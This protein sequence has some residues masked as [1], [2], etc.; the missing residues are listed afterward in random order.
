[1]MIVPAHAKVYL[2]LGYTDIRR[3]MKGLAMPTQDVLRKDVLRKDGP[4]VCLPQ[5]ENVDAGDPVIGRQRA[6][7]CID[8]DPLALC[9]EDI[10]GDIARIREDQP[11]IIQEIPAIRPRR[12]ALPDHLLREDLRLDVEGE[13]CICCGDTPL[14][15]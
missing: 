8:P 2:A 6:L 13:V 9:L 4:S 12:Q 3:G 11:S 15:R 7:V 1:M 10:G 5:Q 14:Y